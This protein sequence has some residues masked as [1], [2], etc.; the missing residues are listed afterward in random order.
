MRDVIEQKMAIGSQSAPCNCGGYADEQEEQPTKDEIA[1]YDCGRSYSCCTSVFK[2]R[3]CKKEFIA[4]F[5]A[6]DF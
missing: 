5:E 2:C 1:A 6:P 4:R 3:A